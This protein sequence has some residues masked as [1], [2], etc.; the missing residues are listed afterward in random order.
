MS[1]S[2]QSKVMDNRFVYIYHVFRWSRE[3]NTYA[4]PFS[5]NLISDELTSLTPIFQFWAGWKAL[6]DADAGRVPLWWKRGTQLNYWS[7]GIIM[8]QNS[9]SHTSLMHMARLNSTVESIEYSRVN[10]LAWTRMDFNGFA[11]AVSFNLLAT[12]SGCNFLL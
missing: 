7:T 11:S 6:N 10:Q 3:Q 5:L 8:R 2:K 1:Y 9:N 4:Q 12:Y